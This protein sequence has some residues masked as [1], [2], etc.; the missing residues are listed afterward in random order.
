MSI[1]LSELNAKI[2]GISAQNVDLAEDHSKFSELLDQ[3]GI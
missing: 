3:L 1:K 2:F